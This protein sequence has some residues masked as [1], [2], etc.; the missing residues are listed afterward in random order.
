MFCD[1]EMSTNRKRDLW[2]PIANLEEKYNENRRKFFG[3]RCSEFLVDESM[4]AYRPRTRKTGD[5]PHLTFCER[6]PNDL[7]TKIKMLNDVY[8][9]VSITIEIMRGCLPMQEKNM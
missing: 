2:W 7:G 9:G 3:K 4:S 6:K 5:L 8:T 1:K